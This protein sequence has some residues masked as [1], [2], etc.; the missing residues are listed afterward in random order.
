MNPKTFRKLHIFQLCVFGPGQSH[1]A[2]ENFSKFLSGFFLRPNFG[3]SNF[4]VYG[5]TCVGIKPPD[6]K[7]KREK[8]RERKK[9][10]EGEREKERERERESE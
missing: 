9:E 6:H 5:K 8:E 1:L 10:G 3:V 7:P 4:R 2:L